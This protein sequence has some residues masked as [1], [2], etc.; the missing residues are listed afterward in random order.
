MSFWKGANFP[1]GDV[2][3][4]SVLSLNACDSDNEI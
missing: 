1:A 4:V 2:C 3:S